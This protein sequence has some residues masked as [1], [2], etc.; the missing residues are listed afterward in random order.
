MVT[1][2]KKQSRSGCQYIVCAA[3][4]LTL[5]PLACKA[6]PAYDR[7]Y[8]MYAKGEVEYALIIWEHAAEKGNTASQYVLGL[9]NLRNEIP[10]A[11]LAKALKYFEVAANK[12][13][14]GASYNLGIAYLNGA[15]TAYDESKAIQY[16][17]KAAEQGHASAQYNLGLM[18]Y[19]GTK[20]GMQDKQLGFD[21]LNRA[22][23][24][25]HEEALQLVNA[26]DKHKQTIAANKARDADKAEL[27]E[28]AP[29]VSESASTMPIDLIV[30]THNASKQIPLYHRPSGI[31]SGYLPRNS[32]WAVINKVNDWLAVTPKTGMPVWVYSKYVQ[33]DGGTS[34]GKVLAEGVRGR[35]L[36]SVDNSKS[37]PIGLFFM[38]ESLE[39]LDSQVDWV[40]LRGPL[41][42]TVWIRES[43]FL[44]VDGNDDLTKNKTSAVVFT[45]TARHNRQILGF[46][47]I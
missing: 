25:G 41:R 44:L 30:F 22:S 23:N 24:N 20:Q 11:S 9:L 34:V 31:V 6:Q 46:D 2:H 21:W 28:Q 36:P 38:G 33:I 14:A 35:P 8:S 13:H 47:E 29:A 12:G 32:E 27:A 1:K 26:I 43:D 4:I 3:L 19:P 17:T 45:K 10:G 16:L 5:T 40:R 7:A 15:G 37:P 42:F 18:I 39:I